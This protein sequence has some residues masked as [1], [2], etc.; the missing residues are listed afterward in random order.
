MGGW[1][2][3]GKSNQEGRIEQIDAERGRAK[4]A[5]GALVVDAKLKD[6]KPA[7]APL[8]STQEAW[9]GARY[10]SGTVTQSVPSEID[11]HGWRVAEALDEV[12]RYLDKA[13]LC[14]L[15]QV[16][17]VHGHGTGALRSAVHEFLRHHP[18]ARNFRL[19]DF[20]EGGPAI[21]IVTLK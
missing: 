21:T 20:R 9:S 1:V 13:V 15:Q 2:S 18:H 6:L 3:V 4:I 7:T 8:A 14:H 16:R 12:D 17:I 10:A 19:A 5:I 11:I